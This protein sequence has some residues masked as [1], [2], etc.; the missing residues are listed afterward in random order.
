MCWSA[1]SKVR[2]RARTARQALKFYFPTPEE[3]THR[4][5][6]CLLTCNVYWLLA[7]CQTQLMRQLP[8]EGRI[9]MKVQLPKSP[10]S[11]R[12]QQTEHEFKI[13][14]KKCKQKMI[15][16]ELHTGTSVRSNKI[17][18]AQ[19]QIFLET[20]YIYFYFQ[21]HIHVYIYNSFYEDLEIFNSYCYCSYWMQSEHFLLY[22]S[23]FINQI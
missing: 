1:C 2:N 4:I 14:M 21:I 6:S 23:C 17:Y 22:N 10:I 19:E 20:V 5:L 7:T 11:S 8:L 16:F 18:H 3:C 13:N 15:W 12:N 9:W